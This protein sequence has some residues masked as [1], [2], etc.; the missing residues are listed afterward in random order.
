VGNNSSV[1][2]GI[3]HA[4]G[5]VRSRFEGNSNPDND[6]PFHNVEHTEGVIRR[7][8][9]LLRAMNADPE[10]YDAGVLGA[11]FHDVVQR[12]EENNTADGKCLRKRF[13]VQNETDSAAEGVA[14][15]KATG[16]FSDAQCDLMTRAILGTVP[17]W[18]PENKTVS[19]PRVP[20]DATPAVRAVAM[21]D[22]GIPGMDG[23]GDFVRTGDALFRE[24]N[25]DVNRALRAC[26]SRSGI[27]PE[28]LEAYKARIMGW[29][30]GQISYARGRR[31]RLAIELGELS[32]AARAAVEALFGRFDDSI[33]A[34]E[35]AVRQRDA[36]APWEVLRATGYSVPSA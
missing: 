20:A 6:M 15:M 22:L 4:L 8:Q 19:Q 16:G 28:A 34:A 33:A 11:A 14:W 7:T 1:A 21:S 13:V 12:W 25:L 26:Q 27:A 35:E 5:L 24:E 18:D 36:M 30:R 31:A 10:E 29:C 32:G 17:S 23:G 9:A 2:S 3:A